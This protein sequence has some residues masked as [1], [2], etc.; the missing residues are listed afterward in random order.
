MLIA[1][2]NNNAIRE[3]FEVHA[4]L[5]GAV[6]ANLSITASNYYLKDSA[7]VNYS[8]IH[9]ADLS[10]EG[11]PV[12]GSCSLYEE[13]A[14]SA[15]RGHIGILSNT[16]GLMYLDVYSDRRI[17]SITVKLN[18]S[19]HIMSSIDADYLEV[20]PVMVFRTNWLSP[21]QKCIT[22]SIT[23]TTRVVVES[24]T[25][26]VTIDFDNSNIIS[27]DLDLA[28]NL[29]LNPTFEVSSIELKAYWPD[30]V[31]EAISKIN[32]DV[33]IWYFSGYPGDYSETR[34]FYLSEKAKQEKGVI[35]LKGEDSSARLEDYELKSR[36]LSHKKN[37]GKK[38]LYNDFANAITKAGVKLRH[39]EIAPTGSGGATM[40]AV[41]EKMSAR[42]YINE[43][44]NVGHYSN[45]WPIFT[46][47]GIPTISH[48]KPTYRRQFQAEAFTIYEKD[49]ADVVREFEKVI[50]KITGNSNDYALST[51]ATAGARITLNSQDVKQGKK[52][53]VN[54]DGFNKSISFNNA[55]SH[56]ESATDATYIAKKSGKSSITGIPINLKKQ[57]NVIASERNGVKM[58]YAPRFHGSI[59]NGSSYVFPVYQSLFSRSNVT[60]S[61][62]WKGHPKMQPR[63]IFT[64]VRLDGTEE[65]CTVERI[66]LKHEAGGTYCTINYRTGVV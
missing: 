4:G 50:N 17:D 3:P 9:L 42:D 7:T 64:F 35:T 1:T 38:V 46:D 15:E 26:G 53:N 51:T 62:T 52:Y 66:N 32:D 60:G 57:Y 16:S 39:K 11:F 6:T 58:D 43:V 48:S 27:I 54:F 31:G 28:S 41:A 8:A 25:A 61:F 18:G 29:S 20:K 65:I 45:F 21:N 40:H 22:L 30:D 37:E 49:C 12:N 14:P 47:A 36:V 34:Y 10:G 55:S 2:S 44:M 13:E 63:D 19:G 24:V 5:I 23:P 56:E 59:Y 33:P